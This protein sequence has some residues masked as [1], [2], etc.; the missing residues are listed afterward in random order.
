MEASRAVHN[1]IIIIM[2]HHHASSLGV[3]GVVSG[4]AAAAAAVGGGVVAGAGVGAGAGAVVAVVA[5]CHSITAISQSSLRRK[6]CMFNTK[7]M[8][9][10]LSNKSS[11]QIRQATTFLVQQQLK[12]CQEPASHR[13]THNPNR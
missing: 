3:G 9:P 1:T 4:V 5:L 2:H 12:Q 11:D 10:A 7:P 13:H 8:L 6:F